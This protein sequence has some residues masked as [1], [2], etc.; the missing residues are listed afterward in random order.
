MRRKKGRW[1]ETLKSGEVEMEEFGDDGGGDI[2]DSIN[3]DHQRF[4]GCYLLASLS[5]RHKGHTYIGFT[6]NPRRR[7]RQHNGEI[8]SG[9]WRTKKKRPW[10]MAL[11][12][13]GFPTH[14][15]ALQFEW[16]WQHPRESVAVRETASSFKSLSGLTNK[17]KLAYAM[18][19]LHTWRT[20]HL[21]LNFFSTKYMNH[22]AGCPTLPSQM[23]VQICSMDDLPCYSRGLHAD[24]AAASQEDH[25]S[26]DT[27]RQQYGD[28]GNIITASTCEEALVEGHF[29]NDDV[30]NHNMKP[31]F[32]PFDGGQ[33][34]WINEKLRDDCYPSSDNH[35]R[36]CQVDILSMSISPSANGMPGIIAPA[37]RDLVF[38]YKSSGLS[39]PETLAGITQSCLGDEIEVIDLFTPSPASQ[40]KTHNKKRRVSTIC[41]EIIDLTRSPIFIQL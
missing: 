16:A 2:R 30:V 38:S 37:V 41:P 4:F 21:T 33:G 28:E 35:D 15:A 39:L 31:A 3:G 14:V 36:P 17:I 13:Y 5:P 24:A 10:E 7:I 11:C 19:T 20:M 23:K 27:V 34:H 8:R 32:G 22:I 26:D 18:L 25:Y 1:S 9:A 29:M 6:V 12:I 40:T